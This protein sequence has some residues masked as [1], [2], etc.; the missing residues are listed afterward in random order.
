MC[1]ITASKLTKA[2]PP[3]SPAS[4]DLSGELASHSLAILPAEPLLDSHKRGIC[5][6]ALSKGPSRR[7]INEC[8]G[9]N[10]IFMSS[11]C[12]GGTTG[13]DQTYVIDC[14]RRPPLTHQGGHYKRNWRCVDEEVCIDL[15][16]SATGGLM[17]ACVSTNDWQETY[18]LPSSSSS[19]SSR[20][21]AQWVW[22]SHD[23]ASSLTPRDFS[24]SIEECPA[25]NEIPIPSDQAFVVRFMGVDETMVLNA[26]QLNLQAQSVHE[27]FGAMSYTTLEGGVSTCSNCSQASLYP[28]P[29]GAQAISASLVLPAGVTGKLFGTWLTV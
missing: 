28:V 1:N 14:W 12:T 27:I 20:S 25:T 21:S 8:W 23:S 17:A 22:L 26:T 16:R 29:A 7:L 15:P 4:A 6:S 2:S 9:Y 18:E 11:R 5:A 24:S 13:D 3:F 10:E 19:G